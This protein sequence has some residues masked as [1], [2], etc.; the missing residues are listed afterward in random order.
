M[1]SS[2]SMT[3]P[4]VTA[5]GFEVAVAL[6]LMSCPAGNTTMVSFRIG[7]FVAGTLRYRARSSS[8][9]LCVSRV[10]KRSRKYVWSRMGWGT[11]E[12][13]PPT[14]IGGWAEGILLGCT[15]DGRDGA[16]LVVIEA[17]K[18]SYSEDTLAAN[19]SSSGGSGIV[20]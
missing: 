11:R 16:L 10:S 8:N 12:A 4:T 3:S 6:T 18:V 5:S 14:V 7:G 9:R 17:R 2:A 1:L 15:S 19:R 13:I 20:Q